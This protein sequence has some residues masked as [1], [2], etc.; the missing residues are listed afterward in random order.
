MHNTLH[1][2]QQY[3]APGAQLQTLVYFCVQEKKK[4]NNSAALG[5]R[6]QCC[7]S[8]PVPLFITAVR[9]T[10]THKNARS[11]VSLRMIC[12]VASPDELF[13]LQ[14]VDPYLKPP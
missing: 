10:H 12:A 9:H 14:E 3:T 2:A 7:L 11:L 8:L 4:K 13:V 6:N 1:C 5:V